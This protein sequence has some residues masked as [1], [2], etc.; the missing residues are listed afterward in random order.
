MNNT[1]A[2]RVGMLCQRED[3]KDILATTPLPPPPP[4]KKEEEE[5]ECSGFMKN[6]N[7]RDE[8]VNC[9][10]CETKESLG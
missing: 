6:K 7:K 10:K 4:K 8:C 3:M 2:L 1:F 9:S 5:G